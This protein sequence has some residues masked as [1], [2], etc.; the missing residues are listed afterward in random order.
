MLLVCY[1][2]DNLADKHKYLDDVFRKKNYNCDFVTRN[3]YRTGP[4]ATN[5]NLTPDTT[6]TIPYIKGTFEIIAGI[7]Q[8]YNIRVAHR[9]ITT[10]RKLLT[11]V[12]Y[13]DQPK[14]RQGA[15]YKIKCCD[16]Q[17]TYIG[18][19]GRN[20]NARLTEHRRA[21]RNGDTNNIIVGHHLQTNRRIDL[22]SA[23]AADC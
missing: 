17:A 14:D 20:L 22:D 11:N 16:C 1:S 8:R 7:L 3:T 9:P 6:V 4:N 18:E 19:T 13:K 10:E 21:T 5:T 2:H 23:A 15:V 12:K